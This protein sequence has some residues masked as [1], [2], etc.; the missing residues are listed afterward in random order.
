MAKQKTQITPLASLLEEANVRPVE[1]AG[2]AGIS[3]PTMHRYL[4]GEREPRLNT[5]IKFRELLSFKLKRAVK[6]Q[7]IFP[8]LTD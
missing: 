5:A 2:Y 1:A 4:T 7:E 8:V 3:K 6:M